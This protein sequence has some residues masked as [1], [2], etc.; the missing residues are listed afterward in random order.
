MKPANNPKIVIVGSGVDLLQSALAAAKSFSYANPSI[1]AVEVDGPEGPEV[2]ASF[3]DMASFHNLLGISEGAF[4]KG[5]LAGLNFGTELCLDGQ[6]PGFVFSDG[7]YGFIIEGLGFHELFGKVR[8]ERP[9]VRYDDYCLSASLA[10]ANR[11]APRSTKAKSI[12]STVRYG[13]LFLR[14]R[15]YGYL[16]A[17]LQG[18]GVSI[19]RANSL[20][21][22][23]VTT[24]S[25]SAPSELG[26]HQIS[27]V[28][29]NGEQALTADLYIDC[30]QS[31]ALAA[32]QLDAHKL[33]FVE[34]RF[35]AP[36][37][38]HTHNEK[39]EKTTKRASARLMFTRD[40]WDQQVAHLDCQSTTSYQ[41]L[42]QGEFS[43]ESNSSDYHM[44]AMM[45]QAWSGNCVA[46]GAACA[47]IPNP[48][49]GPYHL[50]QS[51][52]LLL[53]DVW[54]GGQLLDSARAVFNDF[55]AQLCRHNIDIANWLLH[56]HA[57]R[58]E[59]FELT[60]ANRDR[61]QLFEASG[62]VRPVENA[63]I[64]ADHWAALLLASGY[65]QHGESLKSASIGRDV[66]LAQL[67]KLRELLA[68]A[69]EAA[70]PYE[71]WLATNLNA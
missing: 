53:F 17:L 1:I 51:Q 11:V 2:G 13:Y 4:I 19:V 57:Q 71:K 49:P 41:F 9:A 22:E 60:P 50:L 52:L 15:Y 59:S 32:N 62:A 36:Y 33:E 61:L 24:P 7:P 54:T 70:E 64:A 67:D 18:H 45:T 48:L 40:G 21:V 23:H 20:T 31:R 66:A 27:R 10:K 6:S 35:L 29:I 8:G 56:R 3:S 43:R 25:D 63:V 30:S 37:R 12:F 46:L 68:K 39:C 38:I 28:V 58:P 47:D 55:T 5:S 14:Q 34:P 44:P 65:R 26:K 42:W 69:T 16:N